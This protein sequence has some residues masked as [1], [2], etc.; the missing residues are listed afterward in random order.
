MQELARGNG[1]VKHRASQS[2][3]SGAETFG[4]G[5]GTVDHDSTSD[6][7]TARQDLPSRINERENIHTKPYRVSLR[8]QR[9][10]SKDCEN[11]NLPSPDFS[12]SR[13]PQRQF[14]RR[15]SGADFALLPCESQYCTAVASYG[16]P[17]LYSFLSDRQD[18]IN[19]LAFSLDTAS[20]LLEE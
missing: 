14:P 13:G 11:F 19:L 2:L 7:V 18:G 12:E 4:P 9:E 6:E 16:G 3:K 10:V 5:C 20:P 1:E 15:E 17:L 8:E